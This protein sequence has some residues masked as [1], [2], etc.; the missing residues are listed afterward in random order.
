MPST[1]EPREAWHRFRLEAE[2]MQHYPMSYS[3][4]IGQTHRHV[5]LDDVLPAL[6]QIKAAATL[7]DA[8]ELWLLQNGHKIAKPY[9]DDLNGRLTYLADHAL[10][11]GTDLLHEVRQRRNA[12][13]HEPGTRIDWATLTR[14]IDLIETALVQLGVA[15]ATAM[16]EPYAERSAMKQSAARGVAWERTFEYG[17]R[18]N[19]VTALEVKWTQRFHGSDNA[20]SD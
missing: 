2:A 11:S 19:G 4:Y 16:L 15:R 8:L 9:K 13:A 6:L 7:G 20:Q 12:L 14:D 18:E 1:W 17:V 5:L 10:L 3:L